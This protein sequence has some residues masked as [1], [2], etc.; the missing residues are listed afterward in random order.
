[1]YI[2]YIL[3]VQNNALKPKSIDN[4]LHKH[5]TCDKQ[6]I[7]QKNINEIKILNMNS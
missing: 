1:M 3:I 7:Q 4:K 5:K 6:K 2:N